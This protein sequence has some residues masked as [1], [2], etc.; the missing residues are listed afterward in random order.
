[1]LLSHTVKCVVNSGKLTGTTHV[2]TDNISM[3]NKG[4]SVEVTVPA[5]TFTCSHKK[6]TGFSVTLDVTFSGTF[7]PTHKRAAQQ[8]ISIDENGLKAT[9]TIN[10]FP[11]GKITAFLDAKKG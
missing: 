6:E 5:T 11:N 2:K 10:V 3:V 8:R 4:N 9:L 1:M 7:R